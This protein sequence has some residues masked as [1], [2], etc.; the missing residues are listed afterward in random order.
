MYVIKPN[1]RCNQFPST[2]DQASDSHPKEQSDS[3]HLQ[4]ARPSTL[5]HRR[6]PIDQGLDY[7]VYGLDT[8]CPLKTCPHHFNQSKGLNVS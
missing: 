5:I 8:L 1:A 6:I 2:C 7:D 3:M 4:E